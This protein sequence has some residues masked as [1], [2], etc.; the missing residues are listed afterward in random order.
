MLNYTV[1]YKRVYNIQNKFFLY[2][3]YKLTE[4]QKQKFFTDTAE[5]VLWK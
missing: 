1:K 3:I 4:N 5:F 2:I